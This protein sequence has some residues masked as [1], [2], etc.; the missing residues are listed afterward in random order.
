MKILPTLAKVCTF[1]AFLLF[2]T[3]GAAQLRIVDYNTTD[4][5][6]AGLAT[7]LQAI[8][9]QAVNGFAKPIDVLSLQEQSSSATTTQAIVDLLNGYNGA[10]TYA[11]ATLDGGTNGAGRP[12]LIYN[13]NTVEVNNNVLQL[14]DRRLISNARAVI[15]HNFI[16]PSIVASNGFTIDFDVNPTDSGTGHLVCSSGCRSASPLACLKAMRNPPE[17]C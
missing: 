7:V 3:P 9:E 17:L 12:G 5:P 2:A 13:T 10:G 4:G 14:T 11:R 8:G 1:C 6:R 16:N 15:D